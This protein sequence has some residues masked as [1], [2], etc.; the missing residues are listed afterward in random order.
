LT[1]F[2]G[3]SHLG[4]RVLISVEEVELRL[5]CTLV[6]TFVAARAAWFTLVALH[7]VL[8]YRSKYRSKVR[9]NWAIHLD[10]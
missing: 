8:V 1:P 6:V 7:S 4:D 10:F 9:S 2:L 5:V 3:C